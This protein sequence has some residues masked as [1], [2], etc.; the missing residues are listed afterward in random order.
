MENDLFLYFKID[1]ILIFIHFVY[2][3]IINFRKNL[4]N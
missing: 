4:K 3:V 2:K 1:I